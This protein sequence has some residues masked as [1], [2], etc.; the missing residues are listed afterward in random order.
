M[1]CT[2]QRSSVFIGTRT[3]RSTW[4]VGG[5]EVCAA[6]GKEGERFGKGK[7]VFVIGD[8]GAK[9]LLVGLSCADRRQMGAWFNTG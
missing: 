1:Q 8:Q 7:W 3:A 6:G 4:A 9:G 5:I 2:V